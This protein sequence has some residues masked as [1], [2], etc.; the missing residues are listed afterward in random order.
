MG[1]SHHAFI[2]PSS[3]SAISSSFVTVFQFLL[4]PGIFSTR[5]TLAMD[6]F[7]RVRRNRR[8]YFRRRAKNNAGAKTKA[9]LDRALDLYG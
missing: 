3:F 6:S 9:P 1:R 4:V 5:S 7:G 2:L 8:A